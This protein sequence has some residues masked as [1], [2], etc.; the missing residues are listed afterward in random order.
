NEE[1]EHIPSQHEPHNGS[2]TRRYPTDENDVD[3]FP[4]LHGFLSPPFP[5]LHILASILA[6]GSAV[7]NPFIYAFKN[8]QYQQA[9]AK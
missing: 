4:L 2:A 6:W 1:E 8:R 7:I 3:D 5:D 9:F